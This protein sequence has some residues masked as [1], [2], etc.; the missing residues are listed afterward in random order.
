MELEPVA[1]GGRFF[2]DRSMTREDAFARLKVLVRA[3]QILRSSGA[4]VGTVHIR[5]VVDAHVSAVESKLRDLCRPN[6]VGNL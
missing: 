2:E 5:R 1:V 4:T 3:R 6:V